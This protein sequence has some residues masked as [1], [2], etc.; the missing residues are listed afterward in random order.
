MRKHTQLLVGFIFATSVVWMPFTSNAQQSEKTP[1][2][3]LLGSY[4]PTSPLHINFRQGLR[5]LGYIEGKNII[6]EERYARQC[7][8]ATTSDTFY[9]TDSATMIVSIA[10]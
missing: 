10:G 8:V 9:A 5:E 1:R 6:I 2:I 7:L 3:G 4:S